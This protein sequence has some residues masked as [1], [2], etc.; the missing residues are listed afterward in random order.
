MIYGI[1]QQNFGN[2]KG[3]SGNDRL[4]GESDHDSL[5]GGAFLYQAAA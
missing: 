5:Q 3:N 4:H 1:I 2:S